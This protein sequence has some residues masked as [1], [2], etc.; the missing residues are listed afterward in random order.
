MRTV[1]VSQGLT[2]R[3]LGLMLGGAAVA[4]CAAT[5]P[6][7]RLVGRRPDHVLD[8]P[9]ADT[10]GHA[11]LESM[12][13]QRHSSREFD[14]VALTSTEVGQLLWAGQGVTRSWGGRTAPSAGALYPL[15]LYVAT[16]GRLWHYVPR[17]HRVE[18]WTLQ[19]DLPAELAEAALNQS[20]V[21]T[22]PLVLVV[23]GTTNRSRGKYGGR[24]AR[25]VTL[26]A[27]HAAQNVLLQATALGLASVPVGAFSDEAVRHRLG[28]ADTMTPYYLIAI[29]RPRAATS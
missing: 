6:A 26:E 22:A 14:A 13:A 15:D 5:P 2:R 28:L 4:G 1:T 10:Q 20:S 7:R 29:G 21:R 8:L 18:E 12:L 27:G 24:A 11:L 17:G 9:P 23:A 16:R 3:Q 25:Y 19:A